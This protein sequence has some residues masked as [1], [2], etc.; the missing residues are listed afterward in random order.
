MYGAYMTDRDVEKTY[1][2]GEFV[3][4]L[5]RL[6]NSLEAEQPFEIQVAGKRLYIPASAEWSVEHESEDGANELEF[7]LRWRE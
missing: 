7:Q 6:A 2:R 5:R 1:T 3:E 4:K